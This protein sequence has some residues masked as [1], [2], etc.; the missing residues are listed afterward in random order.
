MS[1]LQSGGKKKGNVDVAKMA[2]GKK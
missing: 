2:E 1:S